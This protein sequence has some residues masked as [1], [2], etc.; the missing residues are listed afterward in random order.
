MGVSPGTLPSR[1]I[2]HF[3]RSLVGASALGK[4]GLFRSLHR[5]PATYGRRPTTGPRPSACG[6]VSPRL[7]CCTFVPPSGEATG[8]V[9]SVVDRLPDRGQERT[10]Q[11]PCGAPD[12]CCSAALC[13]ISQGDCHVKAPAK[14]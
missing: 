7:S 1:E 6:A 9:T 14:G 5:C 4:P 2:A 12:R 10:G 11:P 3:T 8:G 13:P